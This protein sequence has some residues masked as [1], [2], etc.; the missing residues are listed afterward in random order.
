VTEDELLAAVIDL[1]RLRG[2][3]VAHFRP[4]R[5]KDRDGSDRWVTAVQGDGKGY[6]D[7]TIVGPAGV[8]F[9]E[10]K[11]A[12]GTL[13]PEQKGWSLKL[14]AAGADFAVWTPADLRCG[15]ID[16]ELRA[17]RSRNVPAH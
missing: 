8:L 10:L 9:R 1:C 13:S 16:R 14:R 4:A 2:C 12:T 7:L 6:P 5:V 3:T 17:L 15:R 11:S